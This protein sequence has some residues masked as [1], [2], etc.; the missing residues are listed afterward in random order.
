MMFFG[1]EIVFRSLTSAIWCFRFAQF[2]ISPLFDENAKDREVNAVNSGIPVNARIC[3]EN[4]I[5]SL[6]Q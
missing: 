1:R 6:R 2:F 4:T 5:R 3:G